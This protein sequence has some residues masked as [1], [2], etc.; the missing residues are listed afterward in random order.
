MST[1]SAETEPRPLCDITSCYRTQTK[2][3]FVSDA[4][5]KEMN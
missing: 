3:V 2:S 4:F 5:C 1:D